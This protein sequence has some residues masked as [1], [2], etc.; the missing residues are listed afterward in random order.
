M[1]YKARLKPIKNSYSS[2]QSQPM[3]MKESQYGEVSIISR[4]RQTIVENKM[5]DETIANKMKR[6]Y[7]EKCSKGFNTSVNTYMDSL[8]DLYHKLEYSYNNQIKEK[9]KVEEDNPFDDDPVDLSGFEKTM[10]DLK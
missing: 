1:H 2:K 6:L 5:D 3:S 10:S 9:L 8:L 4:P 7:L